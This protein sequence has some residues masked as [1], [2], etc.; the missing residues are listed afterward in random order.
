MNNTTLPSSPYPAPQMFVE[1]EIDLREYINVLIKYWKWIIALALLSAIVAFVVSSF[2]PRSYEAQANVVILKSR[3]EISFDPKFQTVTEDQ[4]NQKGYQDTFVNL[5]T[6]SDVASIVLDKSGNLLEADQRNVLSL[7]KKVKA[8]NA[9]D[10]IGIKVADPDPTVAAQLAN[11]WASTYEAYVNELFS[12]RSSSLLSEV[13]TQAQDI[14]Q[15]YQQAQSALERFLADNQI[16]GL[17]REVK[18]KQ[19]LIKT[20]QDQDATNQGRPAELFEL[21]QNTLKQE[22]ERKYA[23]LKNMDAW[24]EDAQTLRDQLTSTP[25]SSS[26]AIGN[27]LALM[28]LRAKV[29]ANSANLP[30]QLQLNPTDFSANSV[31]VADVDS[32]IDVI[33]ARRNRI[34]TDIT[35]LSTQLKL[36]TVDINLNSP[37]EPI[38]QSIAQLDKEVQKLEADLEA[39]K[40][41]KREL[42]QARDLAWDNYT[43]I[44]RKVAEVQLSSQITS[45]QVRVAANAVVP[46]DP[47]SPRRLLNTAVAGALGLMF[48]VFGV[49]AIE[50]WQTTGD[51]TQLNKPTPATPTTNS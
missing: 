44:Q 22:L 48:A 21:Q 16:A 35:A 33:G 26:A 8:S 46:E 3:T 13:Q 25:S 36:A 51:D 17:E 9:G 10:V 4:T 20:L 27:A 37:S 7:L 11:V 14:A 18:V 34:E 19:D 2:L 5:A 39:Q 12:D 1:D 49:F 15:T 31:S 23:Q 6:S 30:T 29:L 43:T 45:S 28:F 32:L 47:V 38:I 50:Y 40:A 42:S 41:Q 24:L